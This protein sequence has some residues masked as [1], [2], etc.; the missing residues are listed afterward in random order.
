MPNIWPSMNVLGKAVY[1]SVLADLGRSGVNIL[2]DPILLANLTSNLT[3]VNQ[4]LGH[5]FR[6]W[7]DDGLEQVSFDPAS[8]AQDWDLGV[9]PAVLTTTYICQVPR[10][11]NGGALFVSVLVADLVLLQGI[12]MVF[13]LV[14]DNFW[15]KKQVRLRSC[16]GCAGAGIGGGAETEMDELL[17]DRSREDIGAVQTLLK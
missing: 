15:V 11:K 13:R 7:I 1:F 6:Q 8:M 4:T 16:E 2:S 17:V 9:N 5:R 10:I 12:W 14:V 3:T